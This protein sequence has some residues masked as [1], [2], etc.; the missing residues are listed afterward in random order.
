MSVPG[1]RK[2][3]STSRPPGQTS[4]QRVPLMGGDMRRAS[5]MQARR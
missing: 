3:P 2:L 1:G 4:R 5:S